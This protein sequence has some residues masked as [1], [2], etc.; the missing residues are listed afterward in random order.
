M[1]EDSETKR[2]IALEIP[3]EGAERGHGTVVEQDRREGM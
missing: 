2:E 1:G 3:R